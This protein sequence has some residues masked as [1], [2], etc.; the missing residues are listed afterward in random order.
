MLLTYALT[1]ALTCL[2]TQTRESLGDV[3]LLLDLFW[4]MHHRI[5]I[6]S[7]NLVPAAQKH[8]QCCPNRPPPPPS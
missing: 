4:A 2:C 8:R 1:Y 3:F 5:N 7:L 6:V